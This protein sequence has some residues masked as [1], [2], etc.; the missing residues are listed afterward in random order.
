M[1]IGHPDHANILTL[2]M[3]KYDFGKELM[4]KK[5]GTIIYTFNDTKRIMSYKI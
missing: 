4:E 5:N 3:K 2:D 1:I